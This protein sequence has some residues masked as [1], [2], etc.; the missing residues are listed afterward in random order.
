MCWGY[1]DIERMKVEVPRL[2]RPGGLLLVT[3]L[4]WERQERGIVA[5]T[6]ELIA[7]YNAETHGWRNKR[8]PDA[9]VIPKWSRHWLKL[10][11]FHGFMAD[12]PFTRESWRGRIRACRWIGAALSPGRTEAFDREHA[13]LL[14]R[15]APA[16]FDVAHR[17]TVRIFGP[18]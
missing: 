8:N 14:E 5:E 18:T 10:K 16:R 6:H 1:F 15:V 12:I 9:D 17:I 3:T 7:K 2:L 13:A 4:I 11:T